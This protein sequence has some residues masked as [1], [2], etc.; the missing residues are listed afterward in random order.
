ML[1]AILLLALLPATATV[2]G[3]VRTAGSH[4]PIAHA[5][6]RLPELGRDVATD[7]HGYF[8][9]TGVPAGTWR[10]QALAL[11]HRAHEVSVLVPR[12]GSVRV[13]LELE[14]Q[15]YELPPIQ[16]VARRRG[17]GEAAEAGAA[18][19]GPGEIRLTAAA[20]DQIPALAEPDVFRA[21]HTLPSVSAASDYSTALYVR[22]GAPDQTLILLD[23][24]PLFNPFHL[25]GLFAAIDPDAVASVDL[26][27]GA[28][29]AQVGDRL[30]GTVGIWTRDGGRDRVRTHGGMGVVSSRIGADGPLPGGRGSWLVSGRR[31]YL[32]LATDLA[33]AAGLLGETLPY[34]FADLHL[35]VTH[36]VGEL[37]RVS[38]ALYVDDERLYSDEDFE[39]FGRSDWA[40]G[41]R[42]A[43]VRYR[44]PWGSW[45]AEARVAASGFG[46]RLASNA[47]DDGGGFGKLLHGRSRMEDVLAGVDLS[48][49]GVAHRLQAGA[50]L[51]RYRFEHQ[52]DNDLGS[53]Q[54][55]T[56]I[57][58]LARSDR[59]ATLAAYVEDTWTPTDALSLRAGVRV[60]H[61]GG[62]GT[63]WMPRVGARLAVTPRLSLS[64]GAGRYAQ[65]V[66]TLRDEE[67]LRASMYAY[68]L[69]VAAEPEIGMPTSEDVVLGAEWSTPSTG[70]RVDAY[71]VRM[72]NLALP[73]LPSEPV[74]AP[75]LVADRFLRG[76]G[77]SRGL[78]VMARH[79][80]GGAELSASYALLFAGRRVEG[81]AYTP[82]FERRHMLDLMG[83]L[84]LGAR[85]QAS[86]RLVLGTGQ[87]YTPV[88]SWYAPYGFDAR[89]GSFTSSPNNGGVYGTRVVLEPHN[90]ARLPGYVRVDLAARRTFHPTVLGRRVEVTPFVQ[91][92]N[93]LN[94][95]N[96]L[97]VAPETGSGTP[98]FRHSPQLPVLPTLG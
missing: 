25:A 82:R 28:L 64:L 95:R 12:Q 41:S 77:S 37:G 86:A 22:G 54:L 50:Q 67:A 15:P 42:A 69:L 59:L 84:P 31:T 70:V 45:L 1:A 43:S 39:F 58:S 48:R 81:V 89:T 56:F 32:D 96:V 21:L 14:A 73:P 26:R 33:H 17:P 16:I 62:L 90:S 83:A 5:V 3:T 47:S 55:E 88:R 87:S 24:A 97:S 9:A 80:R 94:T 98:H 36:D 74:D 51:D 85:G 4:E 61:A 46:A 40:W 52:I 35:K 49:H 60:L 11:G 53:G 66:H 19:A 93:A 30:S 29:P 57:P 75:V 72:S 18:A 20:M 78:E 2:Q 65:A 76:T 92:L 68:E 23:G 44:Q 13:E 8:V 34:A 91:V 38:A 27:P 71:A 6:V 79:S 7:Q 63:E 10:I